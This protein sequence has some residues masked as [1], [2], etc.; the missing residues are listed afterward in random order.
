VPQEEPELAIAGVGMRVEMH[1]RHPAEAVSV[2]HARGVRKCN[3][4]VTAE[5]EGNC[6]GSDHS[7]DDVLERGESADDV[8]GRHL[9]VAR[10]DDNEVL[11]C[12]DPKTQMRTRPVMRQVAGGTDGGGPE[13]RTRAIRRAAVERRTN[14]D[15]ISVGESRGIGEIAARHSKQGDVRAEHRAG[16][17]ARLRDRGGDVGE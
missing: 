6:P 17:Y 16:L 2:R 3:R 11:Q 15:D 4:M 14:D 13:S 10:I 8:S 7:G 12:I 9:D 1:D 5:N